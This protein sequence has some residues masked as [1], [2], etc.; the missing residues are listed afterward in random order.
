MPQQ[1]AQRRFHCGLHGLSVS[2]KIAD[3]SLEL[4]K[5]FRDV[6][7]HKISAK[8]LPTVM[9]PPHLDLQYTRAPVCLAQC[10]PPSVTKL[11]K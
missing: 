5:A 2:G 7:N 8:I 3:P 1:E 11:W 6:V 9:C 10:P 4:G